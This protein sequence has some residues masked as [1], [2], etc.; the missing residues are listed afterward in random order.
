MALVLTYGST[1]TSGTDDVKA[2]KGLAEAEGLW[3]HVDAAYAGAAWSLERFKEDA[4][5]VSEVVTSVPLGRHHMP[6]STML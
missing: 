3:V 5:A 4:G 2:F 1:N 6:C